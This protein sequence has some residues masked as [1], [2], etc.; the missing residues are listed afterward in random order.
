MCARAFGYK[1]ILWDNFVLYGASYYRK[2]CKYYIS[3]DCMWMIYNI[4]KKLK[5]HNKTK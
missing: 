2:C 3:K 5:I 1:D 4:T